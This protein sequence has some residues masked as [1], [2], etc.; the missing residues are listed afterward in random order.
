[1][2]KLLTILVALSGAIG[3]GAFLVEYF[4]PERRELRHLRRKRRK[5][6][7]EIRK[8]LQVGTD[9]DRLTALYKQ[10][11]QLNGLI[12]KLERQLSRDDRR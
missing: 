5:V 2:I 11:V 8:C 12:A 10:R 6:N 1:M 4:Q 9:N 3:G 7:N